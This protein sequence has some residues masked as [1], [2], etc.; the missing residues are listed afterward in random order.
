MN[1]L[2][3]WAKTCMNGINKILTKKT[4][5]RTIPFAHIL[6]TYDKTLRK[7]KGWK[8]KNSDLWSL[9]VERGKC[10]SRVSLRSVPAWEPL[11]VLSLKSPSSL[12]IIAKLRLSGLKNKSSF[13][14]F[15]PIIYISAARTAIGHIGSFKSTLL[16][17]IIRNLRLN[18]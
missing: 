6:K 15:G 1:K 14:K 17:H 7:A 8:T 10:I 12:P 13:N 4:T 9:C 5:Q 16:E 11:W 18:L 3:L 2:K